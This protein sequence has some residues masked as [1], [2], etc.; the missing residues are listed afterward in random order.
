[1]TKQCAFKEHLI[2]INSDCTPEE[3]QVGLTYLSHLA[4]AF[5][6]HDEIWP[7]GSTLSVNREKVGGGEDSLFP[8]RGGVERHSLCC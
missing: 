1:M 5:H 6:V 7:E 3:S 8:V 2:K 4:S